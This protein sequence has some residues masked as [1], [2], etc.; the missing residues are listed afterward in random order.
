MK[1]DLSYIL[2]TLFQ[3]VQVFDHLFLYVINYFVCINRHTICF[4]RCTHL[5]KTIKI[6]YCLQWSL[7]C[8][9]CINV[10][11]YANFHTMKTL[12][13]CLVIACLH[14]YY[15]YNICL[16]FWCKCPPLSNVEWIL[17]KSMNLLWDIP[18]VKNEFLI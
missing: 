2:W 15:T 14:L 13:N 12:Y 7:F 17:L 1:K 6:V 3:F 18:S 11:L 9:R 8:N 16:L 10:P 5:K 4:F